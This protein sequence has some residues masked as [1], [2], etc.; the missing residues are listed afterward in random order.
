VLIYLILKST[1]GKIGSAG[2]GCSCE[3]MHSFE[4]KQL[5]EAAEQALKKDF[6]C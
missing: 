2:K 6:G 1:S 5:G 4:I 3:Q